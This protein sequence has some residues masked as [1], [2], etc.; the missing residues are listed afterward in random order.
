MV[1]GTAPLAAALDSGADLLDQ[2]LAVLRAAAPQPDPGA[3]PTGAADRMLLAVH[4]AVLGRALEHTVACPGCAALTT[5]PLGRADVGEHWPRSAW[6]GPGIGAREPSYADL[7]AA[8]G[9]PE[10]LLAACRIGTGATL[11]DV[12]RIEG[13]LCGPLHANCPECGTALDVDVDVVALVLGALWQISLELDREVHLLATAYGWDLATI[14]SLPDER[15]RRLA[16][17]VVGSAP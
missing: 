7:L 17:M 14:E 13:S 15:R 16:A 11:D 2:A 6:C 5:L 8:R 12:A 10:M 1:V 9:D 4:E 3:L